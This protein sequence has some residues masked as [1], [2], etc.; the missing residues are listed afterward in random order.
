MPVPVP[1]PLA[2]RSMEELMALAYHHPA[3]PL[4]TL[5]SISQAGRWAAA[6]VTRCQMQ[7]RA[8]RTFSLLGVRVAGIG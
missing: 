4:A 3:Q 5:A 2:D 7:T 6:T 8:C 1:V